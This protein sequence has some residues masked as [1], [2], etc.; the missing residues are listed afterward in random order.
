M[1]HPKNSGTQL[2]RA[3][4]MLSEGVPSLGP[5]CLPQQTPS[6][7]YGYSREGPHC[8]VIYGKQIKYL[9]AVRIENFSSY[10]SNFSID[11]LL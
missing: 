2:T 6:S 1:L 3:G 11:I 9:Y 5:P 7:P 10:F 8:A 4:E